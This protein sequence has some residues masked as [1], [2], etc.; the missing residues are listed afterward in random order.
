MKEYK[1]TESEEK[2]AELG[3]MYR[4]YETGRACESSTRWMDA[5]CTCAG[6]TNESD[7]RY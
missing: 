5:A 6:T 1:L 3:S 2:F 4:A 7:A